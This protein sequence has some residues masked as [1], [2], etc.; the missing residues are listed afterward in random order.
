MIRRQQGDVTIY[1]IKGRGR[2]EQ[3][4]E[5]VCLLTKIWGDS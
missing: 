5:V 3:Q 2:G 1:K 4:Y